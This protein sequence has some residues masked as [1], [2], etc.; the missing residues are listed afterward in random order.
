MSVPG[1]GHGKGLNPQ[2]PDSKAVGKGV[3]SVT[4]SDAFCVQCR[5]PAALPPESAAR[6]EIIWTTRLRQSKLIK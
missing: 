3:W 6:A 2:F 4:G 5:N 1:E